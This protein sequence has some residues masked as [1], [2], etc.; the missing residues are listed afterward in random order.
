MSIG[1][2]LWNGVSGLNSFS[3]A[4]TTVS[5]NIANA[6]TTGF[7][8]G[9]VHFG[10]MVNTY[11]ALQSDSVQSEGGGS[12]IL[13]IASDFAQGNLQTTTMWSDLAVSGEGFFIVKGVEGDV[14]LAQ[15]NYTRDGSFR[16]DKD[17]Y[18]VNLQGFRVQG[19]ANPPEDPAADPLVYP[20]PPVYDY[21]TLVDIRI[22]DADEYQ[23]NVDKDGAIHAIDADGGTN[24][25]R[26][27]VGLARFINNDGLIRQGGNRYIAGDKVG[28]ISKNDAD[29]ATGFG[30]IEDRQ[31]EGSNVDMAKE[32]VNMIIFQSSYNANS[33]TI[34]TSRD[35]LDSTIN[36]VR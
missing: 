35:L 33:K 1:S 9:S 28:D 23:F 20:D 21:T 27:K 31:L 18:L 13:G 32:M 12:A 29:A 22:A 19:Y 30:E 24:E 10:D 34:T 4:L 26:F 14:T 3:T 16:L 15:E 6:N 5:D 7:K 17:G 25:V 8:A 2:S 11:L 36:L